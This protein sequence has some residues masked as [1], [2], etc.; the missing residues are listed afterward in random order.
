[1]YN[2]TS[3]HVL[4]YFLFLIDN[5]QVILDIYY[6]YFILK[7]CKPRKTLSQTRLGAQK[8]CLVV[9]LFTLPLKA[10]A[11]KKDLVCFTINDIYFNVKEKYFFINNKFDLFWN[12]YGW[13]C[14][15]SGTHYP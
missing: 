2:G 8:I 15:F 7:A 12:R 5:K 1:M 3:I 11:Y 13:I 9:E 14:L 4:K 6:S 10:K